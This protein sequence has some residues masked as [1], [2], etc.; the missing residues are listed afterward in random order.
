MC[1]RTLACASSISRM[2]R[3]LYLSVIGFLA[4]GGGSAAARVLVSIVVAPRWRLRSRRTPGPAKSRA[5]AFGGTALLRCALAVGAGAA[6]LGRGL[7]D[8]FR[9]PL[10]HR[11]R[12]RGAG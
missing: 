7:R 10:G 3:A 2:R 5:S 1:S 8:L 12:A 4:D 9:R 11:G 6:G